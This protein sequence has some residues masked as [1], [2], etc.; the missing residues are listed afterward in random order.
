MTC[1][2]RRPLCNNQTNPEHPLKQQTRRR[3]D[4]SRRPRGVGA[5]VAIL[6]KE[7]GIDRDGDRPPHPRVK[8]ESRRRRARGR[9]GLRGRR[10]QE[11]PRRSVSFYPAPQQGWPYAC[12]CW[13]RGRWRKE[14]EEQE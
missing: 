5:G 12:M 11:P 13:R 10:A 6:P 8:E 7:V 3:A 4:A 2:L 1:F 9:P 14:D